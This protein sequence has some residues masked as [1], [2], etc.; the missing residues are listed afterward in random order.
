VPGSAC[1]FPHDEIPNVKRERKTY[2]D[3]VKKH[4]EERVRDKKR[5]LK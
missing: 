4:G 1:Y 2:K 5:R 3:W